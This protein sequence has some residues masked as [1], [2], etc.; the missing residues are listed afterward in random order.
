MNSLN[1]FLTQAA[2]E[3]YKDADKIYQQS[4]NYM[5]NFVPPPQGK[6]DFVI[7]VGGGTGISAQAMLE[8]GA[9][10]L[11][12]LE[13]SETM[14][15]K[16]QERLGD[17]ASYSN[18]AVEHLGSQLKE[19]AQTIYALNCFHLF[20][21]P[22]LA[23]ANINQCLNANGIFAFNLSKPM[24]V[25]DIQTSEEAE[26]L[27]ANLEFYQKL[28]KLSGE[29]IPI[30]KTTATLLERLIA[31]EAK[32]YSKENISDLCK[33]LEMKL[34]DYREVVLELESEDQRSIWTII[35]S[36]YL[37]DA[38]QISDLVNSIKLAENV[39]MRQGLYKII[40]SV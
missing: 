33:S 24:F 21:D 22:G 37:N 13:P 28:N 11:C 5:M 30:L 12:V 8:H 38:E 15:F 1:P 18:L 31:G 23:L 20:P 6:D 35:A 39:Y 29:S 14:I 9:K 36:S 7:D 3:K 17:K 26:V 2:S 34:D 16:A 32:V 25:S 10:N 27:K 19:K 40:K 4:A